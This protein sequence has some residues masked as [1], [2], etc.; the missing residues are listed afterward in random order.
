MAAY[1]YLEVRKA[2]P[3]HDDDDDDDDDDVHQQKA[4]YMY[5]H[6]CLCY[7]LQFRF[8]S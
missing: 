8:V 2:N 5:I 6:E 7:A 3:C 4:I 1:P